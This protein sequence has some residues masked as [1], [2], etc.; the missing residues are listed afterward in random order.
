MDLED[1]HTKAPSTL[2]ASKQDTATKA[3]LNELQANQ[4][5]YLFNFDWL[6]QAATETTI[7]LQKTSRG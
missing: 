3:S 7:G 6:Q 1:R 2:A 4:F 5:V